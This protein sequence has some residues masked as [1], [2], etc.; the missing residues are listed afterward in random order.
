MKEKFT[1]NQENAINMFMVFGMM[2]KAVEHAA[3]IDISMLFSREDKRQ[4]NRAR[5]EIDKLIR[6]FSAK[7]PKD[8][9]EFMDDGAFA[10]LDTI[11]LM[12]NPEHADKV[13]NLFMMMKL[14]VDGN[15][16]IKDDSGEEL[17]IEK[18]ALYVKEANKSE[19]K[20]E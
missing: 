5:A 19:K 7:F 17:Q 11:A 9:R 16:S 10:F 6:M 18:D 1:V 14:Y 15:G 12:R 20:A 4:Y 3:V 13:K 2:L 8:A